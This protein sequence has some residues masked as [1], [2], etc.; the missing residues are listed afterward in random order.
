MGWLL[1]IFSGVITGLITM[2]AAFVT[3]DMAVRWHNVSPFEGEAGFAVIGLAA[4]GLFGG[5]VI[6][7]VAS[8]IVAARPKLANEASGSESAASEPLELPLRH[9]LGSSQLSASPRASW[10][11]CP[12]LWM[13]RSCCWRRRFAGPRARHQQ[14]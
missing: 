12:R 14:H 13:A 6:G 10:Q 9:S 11:T 1:S 3:A 5:F 8:R 2:V 4:V 7:I